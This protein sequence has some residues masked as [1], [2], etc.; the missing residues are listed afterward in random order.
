MH[1][2]EKRDEQHQHHEPDRV[3]FEG[4]SRD[5]LICHQPEGHY[6][7]GGPHRHGAGEGPEHVVEDLVPEQKDRIIP[8]LPAVGVLVAGPLPLLDVEREVERADEEEQHHRVPGEDRRDPPKFEGL[9]GREAR[10]QERPCEDR[11]AGIEQVPRQEIARP[12]KGPFQHS[13]RPVRQR[14]QRWRLDI[15]RRLPVA[16]PV[17]HIHVSIGHGSGPPS[18][19]PRFPPGSDASSVIRLQAQRENGDLGVIPSPNRRQLDALPARP[20]SCYANRREAKL[21]AQNRG[22]G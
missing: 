14:E 19:A 4:D 2:P 5:V 11:D 18:G 13:E 10:R 22:N 7:E 12:R 17:A 20:Q 8:R 1:L 16:A 6:L 9:H 15:R 3:R 21:L